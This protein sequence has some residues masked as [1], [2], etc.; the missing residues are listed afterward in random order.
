M[1]CCTVRLACLI[2]AASVRSEPGSNSPYKIPFVTD[3]SLSVLFS[4]CFEPVSQ[5]V[6]LVK[7]PGSLLLP[8]N[9][10]RAIRTIQFFKEHRNFS[11]S[12]FS[13]F[14]HSDQAEQRVLNLARFFVL[15]STVLS[16]FRFFFR[17][18]EFS[19][20]GGLSGK[21]IRNACFGPEKKVLNA[22]VQLERSS[23]FLRRMRLN[24]SHFPYLSNQKQNFFL[25]FLHLST[26]KERKER[27]P[28][29][30]LRSNDGA[31]HASR[32]IRTCLRP[33][34]A[35]CPPGHLSPSE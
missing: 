33:H 7:T 3:L 4:L 6:L 5:P 9:L 29:F 23:P 18:P 21:E 27:N 11:K 13:I 8:V 20:F 31:Q 32:S 19:A 1:H 16:F 17:T 25:F 28:S 12:R 24:I 22:T 14:N 30:P 2:H 15:S 34:R 10:T 26:K 35:G